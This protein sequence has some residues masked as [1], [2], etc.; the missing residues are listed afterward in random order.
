[1]Q[2]HSLVILLYFVTLEKSIFVVVVSHCGLAAFHVLMVDQCC[3]LQA[4]LP[5]LPRY[6]RIYFVGA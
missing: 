1:M 2:S 3:W 4:A 5:Q 6:Y